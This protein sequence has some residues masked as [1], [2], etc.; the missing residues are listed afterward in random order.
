MALAA[1]N[2]KLKVVKHSTRLQPRTL[3]QGLPTAEAALSMLPQEHWGLVV[4]W[5]LKPVEQEQSPVA[6]Q[7]QITKCSY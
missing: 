6:T 4:Q 3:P 5:Q 1:V 2:A 7:P